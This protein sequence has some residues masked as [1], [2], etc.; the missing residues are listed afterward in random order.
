MTVKTDL[1]YLHLNFLLLFCCCVFVSSVFCFDL[2]TNCFLFIFLFTNLNFF[3]AG[4]VLWL[5]SGV[6]SYEFLVFSVFLLLWWWCCNFFFV[7]V[8]I[9]LFFLFNFSSTLLYILF[10]CLKCKLLFLNSEKSRF[11]RFSTF[12][13]TGCWFINVFFSV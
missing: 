6:F 11:S 4:F 7:F 2:S 13:V 1:C 8:F 5:F 9:Y 12:C 3:K 10:L